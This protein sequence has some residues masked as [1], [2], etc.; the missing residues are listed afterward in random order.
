M[1]LNRSQKKKM[2]VY[3]IIAAA[4]V[5]VY[6]FLFQTVA[7]KSFVNGL[8]AKISGTPAKTL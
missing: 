1:A 6:Y 3:L 4:A 8:T 5:A 2:K 7:G